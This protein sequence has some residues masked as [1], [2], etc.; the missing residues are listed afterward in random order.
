MSTITILIGIC[1]KESAFLVSDTRTTYGNSHEDEIP[2]MMKFAN[3]NMSFATAGKVLHHQLDTTKKYK[4]GIQLSEIINKKSKPSL[5]EI[6]NSTQSLF[7]MA[8]Y[9]QVK[10]GGTSVIVLFGQDP[11]TKKGFIYEL[12]SPNFEISRKV[13]PGETYFLGA[14]QNSYLEAAQSVYNVMKPSLFDKIKSLIGF[15]EFNLEQWARQTIDSHIS[16]DRTVGYPL[17]MGV[18]GK[19][20]NYSDVIYSPDRS[21]GKEFMIP[22][23]IKQPHWN[24]D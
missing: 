21:I 4:L 23:L 13:K 20:K 9:Q 15:K 11:K 19:D 16:N 8:Y 12:R 1:S 24:N 22:Y 14:H 18:Y 17:I 7:K 2:K 5:E 6:I 10:N 3:I